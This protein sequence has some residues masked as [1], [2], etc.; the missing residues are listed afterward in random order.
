[1][2]HKDIYNRILFCTDLSE[3]AGVAFLHALNIAVGNNNCELI[4]FHVVPEPNAQF[5]KSYIY[6]V[7]EIDSKA[8]SDIDEKIERE[9]IHLIPEDIKWSIKAAVGRADQK[10]IE[11]AESV[12]ADLIVVGRRGSSR[13]GTWFFG[14]TVGRIVRKAGCPV[15]VVPPT[16]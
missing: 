11:A 3:H 13:T 1:M 10:I 5:W 12:R 7:E 16:R 9:Y 6:E 8:K 2:P 15:L 4:I 14:N